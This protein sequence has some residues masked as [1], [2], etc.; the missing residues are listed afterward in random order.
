MPTH[1]M[2]TRAKADI[3]KPPERMN[4]H[5]TTTSPLPRS[6]VHALRDP[7]WKEATL[8][9]YNALI[10]NGTW[11]IKYKA[12][13]VANGRNQQQVATIRTVLS[14]AV[15]RNW[16]IHQLDVK[17]V[18]L[19]GRLSETLYMHQPPGFV[20]PNKPD[21]VCHLQ[22]SLYGLKQARVLGFSARIIASLHNEFAMKDLG[23]LNY[24]FGISAQRS[25]S[26]LFLSQLKLAEEIIER[27]HMQNC[28][29]CRTSDDTESK[30]GSDGEPV[31]DP[32]LYRSIAGALQYLTFTRPD[33]SYAVQQ[34]CLYMHDPRDLHF[35]ALKRIL[36]YVRGILDYGMQL[37]V[38]STTQLTAYT[39]A[40]SAGCPVTRRCCNVAETAWIRN[41]LCELCTPL[42]T[43]TLVYCDNVSA[44]YMSANPVQHQRTKHIEIDIHFVRDFVASGQ[45]C[46]LHV[47]SRFQI[48]SQQDGTWHPSYVD[49]R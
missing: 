11:L 43:D 46:V 29:P 7:N 48:I 4:C 16:P 17:N 9:E 25:A 34:V 35:T 1:P 6:H 22:R 20:D 38:S 19:H 39:D 12:R 31:S 33:L 30:L 21:Y 36:R 26:G 2:V 49:L 18:F 28:N 47:P 27:A 24:F 14:L 45:V 42:F 13:L 5:V 8:D 23:S 3:F 32:T 37:H 15:F 44:V 41:L 10:T 40:D